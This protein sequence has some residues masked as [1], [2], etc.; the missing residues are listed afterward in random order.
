MHPLYKLLKNEQDFKWTS[1]CQKV[2]D[3]LKEIIASDEVLVHYNPMLQL[4]LYCDASNYGV[5]A[6]L[7]QIFENG[8]ERP[9]SFASRTLTKAE[10][11]YSQLDKEALSLVF[12][13]KKFH[14]YLYG[15]EFILVT[16]NMP[17]KAIFG[18]KKGIPVMAAG[19]L[20]RYAVFLSGY[21]YKVE[22]V[23]TKK[24]IAD[25]LLRLPL[26][27]NDGTEDKETYTYLNYVETGELPINVEQV[28][29]ATE[30]DDL[31]NKIKTYLK[32]CWPQTVAEEEKP[33]FRRKPE[34]HLE[35]GIVMWEYRVVIPTC[36][37]K[38]VLKD[39]HASHMGI[40]KTKSLIR[41]YIWWPNIDSDVEKEIG[42][43]EQCQKF[44]KAPEKC[45][46]IPWDYPIHT[47]ERIHIDFLGPIGNKTF[48]I[49]IDAYSKW[50]EVF[51]MRTMTTQ[52]TITRLRET[53]ARFGIPTTIVSDNGR[54][55]VSEEFKMFV[56]KNNIVHKTTS[57]Y[58]PATNGAAEN[59][60]RTIKNFLMKVKPF[61]SDFEMQLQRFLM[62]YRN[63][64][65]CTTGV[66]P[67]KLCLGRKL[68]TRLDI[69]KPAKSTEAEAKLRE[70]VKG[71]Q[72]K[73]IRNAR[74][75]RNPTFSKGQIVLCR[76]YP[77]PKLVW[78][79]GQIKKKVGP[80]TFIIKPDAI[81]MTWKRHA[82][83]IMDLNKSECGENASDKT[84]CSISMAVEN[85]NV[86]SVDSN[87]GVFG[88][89]SISEQSDHSPE[90]PVLQRPKR[91]I[92]PPDRYC[93]SIRGERKV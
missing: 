76:D 53:F 27:G 12:E 58:H 85:L 55:L 66:S 19:R 38:A 90:T 60:V 63:T 52:E 80:T 2:F 36:L 77:G 42:N 25:M 54:Q 5:A 45:E 75:K 9:I 10:K 57:P 78:T 68:H 79:E 69:I 82:N 24:N 48:L 91:Q 33:F 4:K 51:Q 84:E 67:A 74:G 70:T 17:L 43:C 39:V 49:I 65:H 56:R 6:V 18:E 89:E 30:Q 35:D 3:E 72:E 13:V 7:M 40:V 87:N 93:C 22:F 92:K 15:R 46:V 11:N 61:S 16:D 47:W 31:L 37:R 34:L 50:I 59:A 26:K 23:N 81:D 29:S 1:K 86:D 20:Q 21:N 8:M 83:Q 32:Q 14:T 73:Q 88:E 28:R 41:S 71:N 62:D 64:P 44:R